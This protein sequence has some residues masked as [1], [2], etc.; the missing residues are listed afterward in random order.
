[1]SR[2]QRVLSALLLVLSVALIA[3]VVVWALDDDDDS[4]SGATGSGTVTA[5][6]LADFAARKGTPV[7]W[8]GERDGETYELTES[9]SG[10][11]YIRYLPAGTAAGDARPDFVTVATYPA[12]SGVGALRKA[13]RVE[14]GAKLGKT[15]DGAVLLIDPALPKNA[16]LVYPGANLQIEVYSP[17]SGE[18]L[19]LAARGAVQPVP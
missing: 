19:R 5:A 16:H 7:Y 10:R 18:A 15:D 9:P 6:E 12:R 8:L 3:V 13:A 14:P 11:V 1:M 17:V 4:S 2:L